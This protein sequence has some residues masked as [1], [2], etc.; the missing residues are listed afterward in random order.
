[1]SFR[2]T[3]GGKT[4]TVSMAYGRSGHR[5]TLGPL[6]VD[7]STPSIAVD[8]TATDAAGNTARPVRLSVTFQ[9]YCTPG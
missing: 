5:G 6:P 2:Y 8:V 9:P 4:S 3:V 7:R 1:V